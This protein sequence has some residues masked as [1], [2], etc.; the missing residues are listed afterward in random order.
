[1]EIG[2]RFFAVAVL[3]I[4]VTTGLGCAAKAPTGYSKKDFNEQLVMAT[5]WV[6]TS[7]EYRALCYQAYNVARATLD[8]DL[9][10]NPTKKKRA[11]IV[12]GDE[13]TLQANPYE[14][15][16]VGR[17]RE[18]PDDWYTFVGEGNLEP[19]PGAQEFLSYAATKGVET[20]YVTNRKV[21]LEDKGT[22][23]NLKKFG[24]PF[25]DKEHLIFRQKGQD[26]N[27][28]SRQSEIAKN[29]H[30][31]MLIGDNLDDHS[32]DFY[33][34]SI[35]ERFVATETHRAKFGT[36][37][38]VLPNPMYGTWERAILDYKKDL[39]AE[40]RDRI[41]KGKFKPWK[42]PPPSGPKT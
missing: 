18:Y 36:Q 42:L 8:K 2:K 13:T 12:D 25:A 32:G 24:F 3:A 1:M 29:Y 41:R 19:I 5:L 17:E 22:Q 33:D 20:F 21:G 40:E 16:L 27:K 15:Y 9:R 39:P 26:N 10:E 7:A 38:I 14:A 23:E 35:D 4:A 37:F 30:V 6:Q 28:Q 34:K 31:V 11:V